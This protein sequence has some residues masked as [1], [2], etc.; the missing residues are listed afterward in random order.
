MAAIE[1]EGVVEGVEAFLA[2]LVAR[3]LDPAV[4][5]HED[6]GAEVGVGVPPVGGAGR[7]AAGAED[8]FVHA[9]EL[10]AVDLGL[11]VLRGELLRFL[12]LEPGF[13]RL[14]GVVEVRHVGD[15]VL[16]DV[17][18]GEGRNLDGLLLGRRRRRPGSAAALGFDVAEAR[19]GVPPA[20]VHGAASADPLAAGPPEGQARVLLVLDLDQRVEHHGT[21]LVEVH[22]VRR[23]VR[24]LTRHLRVVP[25]DLEVLQPLRRRPPSPEAAR[26]K[27]HPPGVAR[28][29][30]QHRFE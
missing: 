20:D 25:V 5:L 12:R 29:Q 14:V 28:N 1:L 17:H 26:Q 24:L 10:L 21:A 13:D 16:H 7:R 4:G 19:Q 6:G 9:V 3:V 15:E 8:A 18:V 11:E 22:R 30:L 2:E 23:Q 27:T